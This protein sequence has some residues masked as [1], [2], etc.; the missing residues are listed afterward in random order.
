MPT[1]KMVTSLPRIEPL[2]D[3]DPLKDAEGALSSE[4]SCLSGVIEVQ[5]Q[6]EAKVARSRQSTLSSKK[7]PEARRIIQRHVSQD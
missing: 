6:I 7:S 4:V 5:E 2:R 1:W 3:G